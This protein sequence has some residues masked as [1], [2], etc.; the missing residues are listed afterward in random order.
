MSDF[1]DVH[2][3]SSIP[4]TAAVRL[5]A[6]QHLPGQAVEAEGWRFGP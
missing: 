2:S 4:A 3:F 6:V 1:N 5:A